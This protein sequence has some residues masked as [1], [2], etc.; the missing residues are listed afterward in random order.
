MFLDSIDQRLITLQDAERQ[1]SI[2]QWIFAKHIA[3]VFSL[4]TK[5]VLDYYS[6]YFGIK[7]FPFVFKVKNCS[8]YFHLVLLSLQ[9]I[10]FWL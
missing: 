6:S 9:A 7:L 1:E 4:C 10:I 3:K 8:F 5:A 2:T